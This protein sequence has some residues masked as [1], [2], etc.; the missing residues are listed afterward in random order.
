VKPHHILRSRGNSE[1]SFL[2]ECRRGRG[3]NG[4]I[5]GAL[6]YPAQEGEAGA[7]RATDCI[8][9]QRR[10]TMDFSYLA[11]ENSFRGSSE[12]VKKEQ[13]AYLPFFQG[14]DRVLDIGCGRGEFLE[15]LRENG[16]AQAYGIEINGDML[17][18]SRSKGLSVLEEDALSHLEKLPDDSLEGIFISHVV[19]HLEPEDFLRLI[20]LAHSKLAGGGVFLSETLNPQSLFSYG[21]YTMDLS[22]VFPVHPLTF[23]FLLEKQ[24]FRE[25]EFR[26]RQYLPPEF[27]TLTPVAGGATPSPLEEAYNDAVKKLQL[28]IDLVFKN[29]IYALAGKK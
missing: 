12:C 18:C 22:H 11:F 17:A 4:I 9:Q 26:Y 15:L 3:R 20:P 16:T 27:L 2:E 7:E 1:Q 24:G 14:R 5:S 8:R 6:L 28:I 19:E 25:M 10:D 13:E 29:F 21:P 23:R